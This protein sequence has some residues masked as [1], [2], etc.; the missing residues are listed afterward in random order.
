M[1]EQ[2]QPDIMA[3]R[4]ELVKRMKEEK[5]PGTKH[6]CHMTH[7]TSTGDQSKIHRTD[8]MGL[9]VVPRTTMD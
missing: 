9:S 1:S 3:E 2:F 7:Y 4:R 6:G 5:K 8:R